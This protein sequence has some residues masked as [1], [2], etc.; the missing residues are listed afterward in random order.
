MK[1]TSR[2]DNIDETNFH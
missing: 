2:S 1:K